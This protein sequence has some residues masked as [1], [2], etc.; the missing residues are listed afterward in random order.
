[1]KLSTGILILVVLAAFPAS[2]LGQVDAPNV[3]AFIERN[4]E[5]LGYAGELVQETNSTKARGLLDAAQKLHEQ[6]VALLDQNAPAMAFRVAV[7]TRETIQQTIAVA[8]RETRVEEQAHKAIERATARHELA[9]TAYEDAG[10]DHANARRL[11]MEAADNLR[12][13][14]DQMNQHMFETALRLAWSSSELSSRALRMLRRDAG[15]GSIADEIDRTQEIL[16][17][18]SDARPSLPA[19]VVPLAD[20]A[21]AMQRRAV[22][23]A[24]RGERER[25]AD[26][27]RGARALALRALRAAGS[28]DE[29]SEERALR[30]VTLTDELI[31]RARA[32]AVESGGD[33]S[34]ALD[35]AARL[36]TSAQEAL[37]RSDYDAATRLSLRARDVARESVRAAEADIDPNTVQVALDRTDESIAK[38][39]E[40]ASDTADRDIVERAQSRQR[41]AREALGRGDLK[42]AL[43]LTKVAH[44]L[45]SQ[46]LRRLGDAGR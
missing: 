5:L 10:G 15:T 26:E 38:L 13:A 11:I 9:R 28:N 44:N 17:R 19:A 8:K 7:R 36:Q 23:S 18:L 25:A 2:T 4:A 39:T 3:R 34:R 30:A 32:L 21:E 35:E 27:T 14:H 43:A 46:A 6:S 40:A 33:D 29:T 16:E 42:R 22:A 37:L 1:M 12:R 45:A 24:G 20:Q 31:E 41:E